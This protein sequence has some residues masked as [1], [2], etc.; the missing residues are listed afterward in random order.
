MIVLEE[1]V[2][3]ATGKVEWGRPKWAY[4]NPDCRHRWW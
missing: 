2:Y 4:Q 3:A 1:R